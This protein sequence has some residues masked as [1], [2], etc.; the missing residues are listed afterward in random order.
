MSRASLTTRRS[1]P[2]PGGHERSRSAGPSRSRNAAVLV[3]VPLAVIDGLAAE[4]S[5]D[6]SVY[7]HLV[8]DSHQNSLEMP[9]ALVALQYQSSR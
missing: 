7:S 5:A 6:G 2:S 1:A 4:G 3:D 8:S 9:E